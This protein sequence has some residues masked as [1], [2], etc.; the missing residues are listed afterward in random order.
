MSEFM[1]IINQ[2]AKKETEI[3]FYHEELSVCSFV[4]TRC[5]AGNSPIL[6]FLS[7]EHFQHQN[8]GIIYQIAIDK[9]K[10]NGKLSIADIIGEDCFDDKNLIKQEIHNLLSI[11]TN[12]ELS[13]IYA[14]ALDEKHKKSKIQWLLQSAT[15]S[16]SGNKPISKIIKEFENL[17]QEF[18]KL[19]YQQTEKNVFNHAESVDDFLNEIEKE[20]ITISTGIDALDKIMG[21]F[22]RGE[23]IVVGGRPGMG[24]TALAIHFL[25]SI[26]DGGHNILNFALEMTNKQNLARAISR[27]SRIVKANFSKEQF[28]YKEILL[29]KYNNNTA[30]RKICHDYRNSK[31]NIIHNYNPNITIDE[32]IRFSEQHSYVLQRDKK[33]LDVII[34]DY[35]QI[36]KMSEERQAHLEIGNITGALKR[37]AKKLN[38]PIILLSQL[39]R[40]LEKSDTIEKKRP[41]LADLR[42]SGKIEEDAD[43]ILFPFRPTYYENLEN[44]ED[45]KRCYEKDYIE[46]VVAKNRNGETGIAK[47]KADMKFNYFE[48]FNEFQS[49]H[50]LTEH[51]LKMKEAKVN[52]KKKGEQYDV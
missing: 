50:G 12:A 17:N 49:T 47:F 26:A 34:I 36:I 35:L 51:G 16:F 44:I 13:R 39:N 46:I 11:N 7:I 33:R 48:D 4:I 8:I 15:D 42:Q 38:I 43:R 24:K 23:L 52:K 32:V 29:K 41:T 22:G 9:F 27:E 3:D 6:D 28:C 14:Y 1:N 45:I 5:L 37:L 40:N 19:T 20:T 2:T 10:S 21:G 31:K 30:F 18:N 25:S